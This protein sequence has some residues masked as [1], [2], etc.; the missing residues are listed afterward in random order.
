VVTPE[1]LPVGY[2]VF[3]G[4]TADVT[5]VEEMVELMEEKYGQAKRIWV[6]DRG[7]IS[8]DNIDFLRARQA[9]YSV[10]TLK[11][12]LRGFE[13]QLLEQDNWA[14]VQDGVEV[15][16]V[17]H[18]DG[19]SDEQYVLCRSSARRQKEAAMIELARQRL[20]ARL[21]KTH[22]S[23]QKRPARDPGLIERRAVSPSRLGPAERPEAGAKCS[24]EKRPVIFKNPSKSPLSPFLTDELG[25]AS[26]RVGFSTTRSLPAAVCVCPTHP[27]TLTGAARSDGPPGPESLRTQTPLP[28]A[29]PAGSRATIR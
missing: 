6:M 15:K 16:L 17:A 13:E 9:R 10:G 12:Q 19:N 24:G 8:E 5:T 26:A 28:A 27:S 23:L 20:R 25:L 2:E 1:G 18:P 11:S 4:H 7:M 14:Q 21:D 29:W 3:A 22:A